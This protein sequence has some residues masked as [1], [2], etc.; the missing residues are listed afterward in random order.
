MQ[1][2]QVGRDGTRERQGGVAHAKV[3]FLLMRRAGKLGQFCLGQFCWDSNAQTG[4]S[5]INR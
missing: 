3:F 1:A 5:L 2:C 4:P